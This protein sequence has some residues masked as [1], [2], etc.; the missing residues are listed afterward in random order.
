MA[1]VPLHEL[2]PSRKICVWLP[3]VV[4]LLTPSAIRFGVHLVVGRAPLSDALADIILGQ[5]VTDNLFLLALIGLAPFATL[6]VFLGWYVK[7]HSAVSSYF[8]CFG[9]LFGILAL[10]I[11]G[12][13]SVWYPLYAGERMSSTAVVAFVLIPIY[14]MATMAMGLLLGW[15]ASLMLPHKAA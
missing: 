12:H 2:P 7:R 6:S 14:C 10:M 4:G 11:P 13:I 5:F 3:V 15:L 9:G 8:L 1:E